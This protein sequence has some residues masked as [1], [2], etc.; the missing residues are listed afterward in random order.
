MQPGD[1]KETVADSSLLEEY[2]GYKPVTTI[3]DGI[4]KFVEWY[5]NFYSIK[6][7]L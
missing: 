7:S 3:K 4:R 1:V 6:Q 2:I 5:K